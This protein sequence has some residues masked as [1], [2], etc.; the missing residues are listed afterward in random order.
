M[1]TYDET[2]EFFAIAGWGPEDD[3]RSAAARDDAGCL[4][5]AQAAAVLVAWIALEI[6]LR[7]CSP[8]DSISTYVHGRFRAAIARIG[9]P[10]RVA[11][12]LELRR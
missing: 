6:H 1:A 11:S 9:L 7:E 8:M 12:G 10:L 3:G 4:G 5:L 2:V